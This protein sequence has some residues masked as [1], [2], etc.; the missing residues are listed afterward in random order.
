[1]PPRKPRSAIALTVLTAL[2]ALAACSGSERPG[3]GP[4][5]AAVDTTADTI[6]V[7]TLS[8]SVWGSTT[9][10]VEEVRI[11]TMEGADEYIIGDPRSIAVGNGGVIYLLDI[12][13]P[14]VRAYAPDGTH[15]YDIGR[16]GSGPGE[17][18][19]PDAMTTLPD[20]RVIVKDPGNARVAVFST[21]GE[22]LE[23]WRHGGGFNTSQRYYVDT[24][25]YSYPMI[26][27]NMGTAPWEWLYG[28]ARTSL[29]GELLDTLAAPTWDYE[30]AQVTGSRERSSSSSQVP[31]TPDM[32]WTF[33]PHGYFVGGLTTDY[34]VDL[35]RTD[36]PHLRIEREWTPVPVGSAEA[37]ER[38]DRITQQFRRQYGSWS[39]NGPEIPGTKPP[40]SELFVDFDGRIWVVLSQKGVATMTEEEARE[41]ERLGGRVPLRF[42]EPPAFD[43][44]DID[45]R[46][47][48]HVR[49]PASMRIEPEPLA[50]GDTV[51]AVVRDELDVPSI[52]RFRMVRG[53]G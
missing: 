46:F 4:W 30:L 35:F 53:E 8:G 27:L 40:Y 2:A 47:L 37:E 1:M 20:G 48:G 31:F 25:G 9:R 41:E 16:A 32:S 17:Y 19:S 3:A 38:H 6:T 39:W 44:F 52:V 14:V 45:G 5:T 24:A 34:R 18:T 21:E 43:V 11:G 12:Q 26:L 10:L 22:F 28:L 36:A 42:Q 50:R 29:S 23:N 15:L 49:P 13:V 33:S 7:R 51:W